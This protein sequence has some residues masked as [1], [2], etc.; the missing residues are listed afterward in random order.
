MARVLRSSEDKRICFFSLKMFHVFP[1]KHIDITITKY[2]G[3]YQQGTCVSFR[4]NAPRRAMS[5]AE[6]AAGV[7]LLKTFH[8]IIIY[9][10]RKYHDS[11]LNQ[12][13][14]TTSWII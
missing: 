7:P 13:I 5:S 14:S 10:V 1:I 9:Q 6:L 3:Y 4:I 2:G 8:L 11:Q 12:I